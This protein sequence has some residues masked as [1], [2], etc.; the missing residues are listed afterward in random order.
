[1]SSKDELKAFLRDMSM[2]KINILFEFVEGP[3]GGGNQFLKALRE[4]FRV[5][6]VYVEDPEGADV[7]L[8][9][10]NKRSLLTLVKKLWRLRFGQN[11]VLINRIDGPIH[12]RNKEFRFLD[13]FIL[14]INTLFMDGCVYQTKWAFERMQEVG[15]TECRSKIIHNA[16]L[17]IFYPSN[18]REKCTNEKNRIIAT[19]WSSNYYAKGFDIYEFLDENLD[20]SRYDMTFVGNSPIQFK[21]IKSNKPIPP[22]ELANIL[23]KHDMYLIASIN[24]PCSNALLE[25]LQCGL[26]AVVR[27]SGG[28]P[29]LVKNGGVKFK[30]RDD[31]LEAINKLIDNIDFYR[32][33]IPVY[34]IDAIGEKYLSFIKEIYNNERRPSDKLTRF[35]RR[36]QWEKL[37]LINLIYQL[38]QKIKK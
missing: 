35:F 17:N 23:R 8:F 4:Y 12:L 5:E 20:F 22:K 31:V 9:N 21:N 37:K 32:R 18:T 33:N 36:L 14:Q 24:D 2:P 29:E 34:S 30:G 10:S 1:M 25:A 7:I 6:G 27:N 38:I 11:K 13:D 3:W 26:P 16:P 15:G 19:S 28:H